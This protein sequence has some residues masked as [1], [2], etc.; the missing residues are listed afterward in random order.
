MRLRGWV[1]VLVSTVVLT[2]LGVA[3]ILVNRSALQAAD[4]VHRSDARALGVN[5]ATLASQLQLL[6][7]KE[8]RDAANSAGFRLLPGDVGD[9]QRLRRL[10]ARS[11]FFS[12]GTALVDLS[13]KLLVA[14]RDSGLPAVDDPRLQVLRTSLLRGEP[15]FSPVITQGSVALTAVAVP[16][17]AGGTPR[18]VLIGFADQRRG[19][20]QTYVQK[21]AAPGEVIAVVDSAGAVAASTDP[22]SIGA[23]ADP[24]VTDGL[25][26]LPP[27]NFLDYR[28]GGTAMTAVVV[29]GIPGGWFYVRT[30]SQESFAGAVSRRNRTTTFALLAMLLIGVGGVFLLGYRVQAQRRR[31][32]QRFR[33]LVQHAPD[34]VAVLDRHA[35]VTYASPSTAGLLGAAEADVIGASVFAFV[36][37]EDRGRLQD[38]FR[39]LVEQPGAVIREQCRIWAGRHS[40]RWM[41]LTA[42]NQLGNPALDGI[43]VNARDVTESRVLQETLTHEALHDSLTGLA[44]RRHMHESLET[45]LRQY[46]VAVLFID[47]DGFKPIHDT[48]GHETGDEVLRLTA[49][50]L[51]AEARP[52]DVVARIGGDEF[53]VLMPGVVRWAEAQ[54]AANRIRRAVAAPIPAGGQT[55]TVS[56]SIGVHVATPADNPDHVLRAA[57]HAMY[58][59]KHADAR[60]G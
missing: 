35:R 20:L 56:A 43:V 38:R 47:L 11:D 36:H 49:R 6:S 25:R 33:A 30:Q 12:Y 40:V 14:S 31:S 51:S 10:A 44:N 60:T 29:G 50:R 26:R 23:P 58:A 16:V 57:D 18:G 17:P 39:A 5:N 45:L 3:G 8:L 9:R 22:A 13:G 24:A 34:V 4:D 28:S 21:L 19:Q 41:E 2:S 52:Y 54:T 59:V 42:T 1:L 46:A 37:P 55:L 15:G 48:F 53:V 7:A 32:D 27:D